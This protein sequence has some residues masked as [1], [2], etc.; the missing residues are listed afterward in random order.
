[1]LIISLS[2]FSDAS[3]ASQHVLR[4]VERAVNL[5]KIIV[6]FKIEESELDPNLAYF[7]SICHWLDAVTP[8]LKS[9]IDELIDTLKKQ[10]S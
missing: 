2:V 8:P 6:P 3:N 9:H 1:M 4:E 5:N 10:I 7:I